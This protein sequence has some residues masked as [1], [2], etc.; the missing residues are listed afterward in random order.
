[1]NEGPK[2]RF[3]MVILLTAAAVIGWIILSNIFGVA[4]AAPALPDGVTLDPSTWFTSTAALAGVVAI[5]TQFVKP[6]LRISGI[7]VKLLAVV[8][9]ALTGALGGVLG[10]VSG[11]VVAGL[12]FGA[13]AGVLAAGGK[14][15]LKS[16][17]GGGGSAP[18]SDAGSLP[19]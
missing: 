10:W 1:M 16:V 3:G 8:L 9:G 19:R 13:G 17:M 5:V 18:P 12:W 4:F 6:H 11:G 7:A 2:F 14:D 15:L